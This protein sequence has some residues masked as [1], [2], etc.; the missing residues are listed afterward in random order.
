MRARWRWQLIL[1]GLLAIIPSAA[2]EPEDELKSATVL[3]FIRHSEWRD[4]GSGPIRIAVLGRRAMIHTLRRNLEGRT[5][6]GR[7][8]QVVEANAQTELR[9]CQ[10]LYIASDNHGEIRQTLAALRAPHAL[11]IGESDRFL[12]YGGAVNLLIVDGHM[13]FEVSPDALDRAGV[14]ISSTLLRYGQVNSAAASHSG[15]P[16]A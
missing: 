3:T 6:N 2:T 7:A 10:V 5:A 15:R 14:T 4:A 8:L 16:P 11:T 9:T 1:L 12:E 13:S